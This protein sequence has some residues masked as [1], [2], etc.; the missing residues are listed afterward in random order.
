MCKVLLTVILMVSINCGVSYAHP[1]EEIEAS[2]FPS[3]DFI[4]GDSSWNVGEM[5]F[6]SLEERV[7]YENLTDLEKYMLAGGV[8]PQT[9]ERFGSWHMSVLREIR[10]YVMNHGSVPESL[11]LEVLNDNVSPWEYPTEGWEWLKNPLSDKA[12][13]L[14][15][16]IPSPGNMFVKVIT[17]EEKIKLSFLHPSFKQAFGLNIDQNPDLGGELD[18][19]PEIE[20]PVLYW[21]LYG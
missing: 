12:V 21:R 13:R 20:G 15:E 17:K 7:P 11:T 10:T 9:G 16:T 1:A 18:T 5:K 14:S 4:A 6:Y 3:Y 2:E 8:N 19:M